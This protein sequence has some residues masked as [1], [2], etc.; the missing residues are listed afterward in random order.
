MM[1]TGV[2][3]YCKEKF[4]VDDYGFGFRCPECGGKIDIFTDDSIIVTLPFGTV[5]IRG[6]GE[7]WNGT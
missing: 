2:C 4:D 7:V 6:L 3:P 5:G 1:D